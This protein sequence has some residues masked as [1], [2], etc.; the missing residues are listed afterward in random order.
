MFTYT[1]N[2]VSEIRQYLA[3]G[4]APGRTLRFN[5]CGE[6]VVVTLAYDMEYDD[7]VYLLKFGATRSRYTSFNKLVT[8][9]E[10]TYNNLCATWDI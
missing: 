7:A 4:I 5:F 1:I 10:K 8:D 3:A 6:P 9:L 2:E